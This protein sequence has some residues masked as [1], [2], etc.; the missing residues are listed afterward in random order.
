MRFVF[1]FV[2]LVAVC[3][4]AGAD[5]PEHEALMQYVQG[6]S[7]FHFDL[8]RKL[9]KGQ[10]LFYSPYS[11]STALALAATGA[12]GE[13]EKEMLSALHLGMDRAKTQLGAAQL[14]QLLNSSPAEE[15]G[16][17]L[18]TANAFWMQKNFSFL[19]DFLSTGKKVFQAELRELNFA[20][21]PEKAR[22]EINQW[23]SDQTHQRIENLL[24]GGTIQ[25]STR[26]V[27]TNA[28][29]FKGSWQ[30]PFPVNQTAS[31]PFFLAPKKTIQVS[32]MKNTFTAN[33]VKT[34]G[35]TVVE[36]P[37]RR[38]SLAMLVVIPDAIQGLPAVENRISPSIINR[39][40]LH[41]NFKRVS[42][43]F[44]KF[45]VTSEFQLEEVLS[46]LGMRHAFDSTA[47]F[48]GITTKEKVSIDSVA[49]KA[50]IEVDEKGTEAA[51]ATGLAYKTTALMEEKP[52]VITADRP[53]LIFIRETDTG[54]ILFSGRIHSPESKTRERHD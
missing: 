22:Q 13:T 31:E 43:R 15:R 33:Y 10:N 5:T 19:P 40:V 23:V 17:S 29:Y 53:F 35:V 27:I 39:W 49:H 20:S 16:Y 51:A 28:V 12:R 26:L 34:D 6:T 37:Y 4:G 52:E 21:D 2:F 46:S 38:S 1:V 42:L 30:E 9:P 54:A 32:M 50:F 47:D 36:L 7:T 3:V 25:K 18:S 48:S 11:V 45:N 8:F 44:P 14:I 24:R 41:F